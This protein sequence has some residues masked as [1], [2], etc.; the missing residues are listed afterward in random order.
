[1]LSGRRLITKSGGVCI[2]EGFNGSRHSLLD[3]KPRPQQGGTAFQCMM[4]ESLRAGQ[5]EHMVFNV[6]NE[7]LGVLVGAGGKLRGQSSLGGAD[8]GL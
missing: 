3:S 1:M 5:A 2:P 4:L 8:S 6:L 7:L